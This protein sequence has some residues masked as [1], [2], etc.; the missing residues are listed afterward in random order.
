MLF[1][2]KSVIEPNRNNKHDV[3]NMYQIIDICVSKLF[4]RYE[5]FGIKIRKTLF[6]DVM[7]ANLSL[8]MSCL[9]QQ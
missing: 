6:L 5:L 4:C 1:S 8:S 3:M 2:E 9:C 7:Q